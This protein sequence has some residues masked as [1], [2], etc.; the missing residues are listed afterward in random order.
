MGLAS[1][2][3]TFKRFFVQGSGTDHVDESLLDLLA[4]HAINADSVR[5]ADQTVFGWV[6][7]V[8]I[9]DTR[10]DSYSTGARQK[11]S[12]VR[13][14]LR[15]ASVILFDEPTRSLDPD[16][17][18]DLLAT[19]RSLA[20]DGRTIVLI[21]HRIDE[22]VSICDRVSVLSHGS[23]VFCDNAERF[24]QAASSNAYEMVIKEL[25]PTVLERLS[26][27]FQ[28]R[29]TH[30]DHSFEIVLPA[31]DPAAL[32][33]ALSMIIDGGAQVAR[34]KPILAGLSK[35]IHEGEES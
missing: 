2:P 27:S 21:T 13:G 18:N 15:D 16:S 29:V 11:L 31:D 14:L 1:G 25:S 22:A 9:L 7:G 34:C 24:S 8:H 19:A 6:T 4:A 33:R 26:A 20:A 17:V 28:V 30:P 10:F 12:L 35:L 5:T 23:L 3:V 32:S